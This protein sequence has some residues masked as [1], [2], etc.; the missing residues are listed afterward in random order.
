M[1]TTFKGSLGSWEAWTWLWCRRVVI[2]CLR[3]RRAHQEPINHLA[4]LERQAKRSLPSA[5][6]DQC[7][8]HCLDLV[9]RAMRILE[10]RISPKNFQIL[11]LR[12]YEE[13]SYDEISITTGFDAR[14]IKRRFEMAL[15]RLRTVLCQDPE[16]DAAGRWALA[17]Y[18]R[19]GGRAPEK[20]RKYLVMC[21]AHV[22]CLTR[23]SRNQ[24]G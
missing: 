10:Q 18:L 9:D 19:G 22:R 6:E 14:R 7:V 12:L 11:R 8:L 2:D 16:L 24:K 23:L 13:R 4:F 21:L 15:M 17:I 20:A 1:W 5:V 3:S